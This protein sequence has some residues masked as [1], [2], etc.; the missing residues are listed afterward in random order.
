LNLGVDL[1]RPH[2]LEEDMNH[3]NRTEGWMIL[4]TVGHLLLP[5]VHSGPASLFMGCHRQE[6]GKTSKIT[7]EK[8]VTAYMRMY[9]LM[10]LELW[11]SRPS[12]PLAM[13]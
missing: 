3:V 6:A 10:E 1:T 13:L 9:L 4:D 11:S 2:T 7:S 8:S 12:P 5:V